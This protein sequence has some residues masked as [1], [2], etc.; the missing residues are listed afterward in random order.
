MIRR[1]FRQRFLRNLRLRLAGYVYWLWLYTHP[2]ERKRLQEEADSA[3][4]A[5]LAWLMAEPD[6]ELQL[7]IDTPLGDDAEEF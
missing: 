2:A 1:Y 6:D 3:A 4:E 5:D 7:A